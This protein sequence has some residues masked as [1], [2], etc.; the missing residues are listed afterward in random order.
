MDAVGTILLG[1]KLLEVDKSITIYQGIPETPAD[2]IRSAE[3]LLNSAV[4]ESSITPRR[5]GELTPIFNEG[6]CAFVYHL[7]EGVV[8]ILF[9]KPGETGE[10]P[11]FL[12]GGLVVKR[13]FRGKGYAKRLFTQLDMVFDRDFPN[14]DGISATLLISIHLLRKSRGYQDITMEQLYKEYGIDRIADRMK[15]PNPNVKVFKKIP[16][17]AQY[18]FTNMRVG[19]A[20]IGYPEFLS[21]LR[22]GR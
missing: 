2:L 9:R 16:S 20:D 15:R 11:H 10:V 19:H 6:F 13:P 8:G 21:V 4:R 18:P 5:K 14:L 7:K 12:P 1:K 22:R 3:K 17:R